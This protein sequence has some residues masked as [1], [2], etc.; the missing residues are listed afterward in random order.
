MDKEGRGCN[1]S[2]PDSGITFTVVRDGANLTLPAFTPVSIGVNPTQIYETISMCLLL[3]FLLSYFPY[4]RR[5]G[6]LMV[7][8][9]FGYAAHRFLDEMLR[10]D[11]DPGKFG[12]GL[13]LM[14]EIS[15]A[16]LALGRD[17]GLLRLAWA[18]DC[19]NTGR[20]TTWAPSTP[21]GP[22]TVYT[23]PGGV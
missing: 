10:L 4:R 16:M 20:E 8:F 12:I 14:Q 22:T 7:F 18:V 2:N 13:T 9:M 1:T 11:V 19:R 23:P 17:P 6:E 3:F 15:I 21:T 5:D